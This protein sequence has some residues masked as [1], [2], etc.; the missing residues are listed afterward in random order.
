M[1][2]TEVNAFVSAYGEFVRTPIEA[3]R[4]GALFWTFDLLADAAENDPELC[5]RLIEAVVA[6]DSDEQVL[7]ALA[8]G[9]MED[10]LARHGPAFIERIETKAA[11]N[12]LFRHLLAGVW[13]NAIP[14][15]IWDRVVAA[16]GPDLG[17]V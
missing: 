3:P 4:S 2:A 17:K 5:W 11:Q 12:P 9:P 16:R 1:N 14:Q 8:A 10:L 6:R 15:E 13:R 7:A